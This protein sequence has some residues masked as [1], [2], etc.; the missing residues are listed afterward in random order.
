MN[1]PPEIKVNYYAPPVEDLIEYITAS[2]VHFM[3]AADVWKKLI[4]KSYYPVSDEYIVKMGFAFSMVAGHKAL[5]Q[6]TENLDIE[7]KHLEWDNC[8]NAVSDFVKEVCQVLDLSIS[9]EHFQF[10]TE[11][12]CAAGKIA[13]ILQDCQRQLQQNSDVVSEQPQ[14]RDHSRP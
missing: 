4:S 7:I 10:S 5:S 6:L 2:K 1:P 3:T 14:S 11:A 13:N 9:P 12:S 8:W